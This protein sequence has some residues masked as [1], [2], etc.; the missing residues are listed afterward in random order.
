M[1]YEM[2][3]ETML[4]PNQATGLLNVMLIDRLGLEGKKPSLLQ[5]ILDGSA[6]RVG[7]VPS[8]LRFERYVGFGDPGFDFDPLS[9]KLERLEWMEPVDSIEMVF[10]DSV[11]MVAAATPID[12]FGVFLPP[13]T[14]RIVSRNREH[15]TVLHFGTN[16][17][18]EDRPSLKTPIELAEGQVFMLREAISPERDAMF[19][20]SGNR[21]SLPQMYFGVTTRGSG[22]EPGFLQPLRF[23][24]KGLGGK[25][26]PD[27]RR[28]R[29]ITSTFD[30][31]TKTPRNP[32]PPLLP[33]EVPPGAFHFVG[34]NSAFGVQ[35]IPGQNS[36]LRLWTAPGEYEVF[37][38]RGPLSTLERFKIDSRPGMGLSSATVTVFQS[39][40]PDGWAAFDV[41][42][43]SIATSGGMVPCEQLA[44]ALVEDVKVVACTEL[45]HQVDAAALYEEFQASLNYKFEFKSAIGAD[46]AD[47][48]IGD[49]LL[50]SARSSDL[51]LFGSATALFGVADANARNGGARPSKGWTLADFLTQAEGEFNVIHRPR[52]PNGIFTQMGFDPDLPLGE[53]AP[54]WRQGGLLSLGRLN[55]DFDA[56][57]LLN[58][59]SLAALGVDDWWREFKETRRDWF[60]LLSQQSPGAFTKALGFSSGK[61]SQDTP[62]GLVRTWLR[63]GDAKLSQRDTGPILEALRKGAAVVSS[64]PM[65]DAKVGGVGP[66]GLAVLDGEASF[67]TLDIILTAPDWM[68]VDEIRVVVNGDVVARV[69]NPKAV[70]VRDDKDSRFFAGTISVPLPAG[71]DAWLVVEA[72]AP[73]EASEALYH[74]QRAWNSLMKGIYPIAVANPIFLNLTAGGYNPP[75]L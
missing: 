23:A 18:N 29:S 71:K 47:T 57:E 60:S 31:N 4:T 45:D 5:F 55:G 59:G 54:W 46:P 21:I 70:L 6:T 49:P 11:S 36:D 14:Y 30:A 7:P 28:M 40:P 38:A 63:V 13:G 52:G 58:A 8:E 24:V 64:G 42:G 2:L 34:G 16:A 74:E 1:E 73:L 72:G 10:G 61:Y 50:V 67:A 22:S 68:P 41:P 43:P 33:G 37:C 66:G 39:R 12:S 69:A 51:G 44:S 48:R 27:V 25:P 19:S 26:D 65:L 20:P 32:G 3:L 75:G 56:L 15:C 62:V 17:L 9:W 53:A 35:M